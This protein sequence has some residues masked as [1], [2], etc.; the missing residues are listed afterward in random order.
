MPSARSYLACPHHEGG[1]DPI[2]T[3]A[4]T[5]PNGLSKGCR[6]STACQPWARLPHSLVP[7]AW[8]TCHAPGLLPSSCKLK[9]FTRPQ[10]FNYLH[11]DRPP[12]SDHHLI[13]SW[14][15]YKAQTQPVML[16]SAAPAQ[17]SP[18]RSDLIADFSVASSPQN[19]STPA[20]VHGTPSAGSGPA[21][22]VPSPSGLLTQPPCP[23]RTP[24]PPPVLL[25]NS[26]F[27]G[28]CPEHNSHSLPCLFI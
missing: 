2:P 4:I 17:Y 13:S 12:T 24:L 19:F 7:G 18:P 5:T 20:G 11:A 15:P 26:P 23:G 25:P 10:G 6:P 27:P 8:P 21:T 16:N 14:G 1:I 9:L 22:A 28:P 3:P